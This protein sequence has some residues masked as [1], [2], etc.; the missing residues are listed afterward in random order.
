MRL[1]DL[2][3]RRS[4]PIVVTTYKVKQTDLERVR[5][6]THM[7]L[8]AELGKPFPLRLRLFDDEMVR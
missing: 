1:R 8:A 7:R 5:F 6:L 2:F 3:R 4:S